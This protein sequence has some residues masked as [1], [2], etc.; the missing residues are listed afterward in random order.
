MTARRVTLGRIAGV[1]GVKGWVKL[2]SL[3]RPIENLLRY[4]RWW[5]TGAGRT[6]YQAQV[7]AGQ[8]QGRGLVAQISGVDGQPIEDRT[9]AASLIGAE[10]QVERAELPKLPKG[11]YYWIDLIGLK[12][13][14]LDGVALGAVTDVTSN[15]PQDVLV[16]KDGEIERLIP[17]VAQHIVKDVDLEAGRI[18]CDWQREYDED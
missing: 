14:N 10:I 3:T 18:V 4:R 13:E 2:H 17:F 1:H 11:R 12:V 7:L 8:P 9:L 16:L 5:I 6:E 15:G